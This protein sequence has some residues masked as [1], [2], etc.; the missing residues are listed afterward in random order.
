MSRIV[1]AGEKSAKKKKEARC[2]QR[3]GGG[4]KILT[5]AGGTVVVAAVATRGGAAG[6]NASLFLD[7]VDRF[8]DYGLVFVFVSGLDLVLDKKRDWWKDSTIHH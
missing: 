1:I 5:W 3:R 4:E 2:Q 7:I 6:M 8:K